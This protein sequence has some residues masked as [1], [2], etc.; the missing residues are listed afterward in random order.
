MATVVLTDHAWPDVTIER[1]LLEGNGHTLIAPYAM[2]ANEQVEALVAAHQ[3]DAIMTC[4]APVS[5]AAVTAS[6]HLRI[7]ARMGV[8][9][10]NIAVGPA[11]ARGAWVTNV[12]DY[13]VDEV[14]DHAVALTLAW[15][16]GVTP[17]DREVRSGTWNPTAARLARL[18]TLTAGII[19]YGRI[20]RRSAT[21]LAALGLQVVALAPRHSSPDPS[22]AVFVDLDTLLNRADVVVLHVPLTPETHHL[23]DAAFL[24]RMRPHALLVN[25]SRGPV[26]DTAA[27]AS[28]LRSGPLAAALDV[29]EGEPTVP[30][31]LIGLPNLIVTPHVGFSS[32][33][34]IV[35]LRRRAS[36]E[37]VRVLAGQQPLHPCNLPKSVSPRV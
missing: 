25:V 2:A 33:V 34:S 11:G 17:L 5:T 20:G 29:V 12:P 31:D 14:S 26:V 1:D 28:A 7:V 35:E 6:P 32:T 19:G 18:N 24:G 10:D 21:K 8:G 16:R 4:W 27:L 3:P 37:V 36:E 13:C 22:P 9:L 23:V 15:F 30:A